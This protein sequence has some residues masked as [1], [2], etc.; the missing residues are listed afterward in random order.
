MAVLTN[1]SSR[2]KTKRNRVWLWLVV[3]ALLTAVDAWALNISQRLSRSVSEINELRVVVRETTTKEGSGAVGQVPARKEFSSAFLQ[4]AFGDNPALLEQ[5]KDALGHAAGDAPSLA[6]GD[7]AMMLVTY[8]SEGEL[9]DVAIH[10]FGN[11]NPAFLPKFSTDGY[12]RGQ[13]ND[14]FFSMGQSSLALLG[15]EVMILA[16]KDVEKRQRDLLESSLNGQYPVVQD[17]LHDP[18]SFIVVIPDPGKLFTEEFRPYI[19]AVLIKGKVS[20]DSARAELVALSYD[21]QKARELAQMLS[22]MRMM[23]LGLGRLRGGDYKAS[24]L[25]YESLS[26]MKVHADGP[27]VVANT[28]LPKELLERALPLF[29]RGLA[30]GTNRIKRGP[31]YPQ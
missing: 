29:V 19:A 23:A 5:I 6:H 27:T 10:V 17:F 30:R 11:L 26:K 16:N 31:G 24:E 4:M 7:V 12:W 22:D 9:R 25:G 2:Y 8:R 14:Q 15:R 1:K 18:V 13:L 3:I 28:V 20:V 21:A